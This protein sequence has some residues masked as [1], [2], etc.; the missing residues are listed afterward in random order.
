MVH[1]TVTDLTIP[2]V[3]EWLIYSQSKNIS[4]DTVRFAI[5]LPYTHIHSSVCTR[6]ELFRTKQFVMVLCKNL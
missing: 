2:T 5:S 6:V 1:C 3:F 4:Q